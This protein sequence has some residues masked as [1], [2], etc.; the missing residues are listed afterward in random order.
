MNRIYHSGAVP[1]AWLLPCAWGL[2]LAAAHVASAAPIEDA[3]AS[4][5]RFSNVAPGVEMLEL[6]VAK[7]SFGKG[8]IDKCRRHLDAARA[9][10]S[11]Q[12]GR[13]ELP[14]TDLMLARL[15][16]AYGKKEIAKGM[17][18]KIAV[19]HAGHPEV[20]LLFGNLALAEG[21]YTDAMLHFEKSLNVGRPA[22]WIE[23]Q[24]KALFYES[25]AGQAKVAER[26]EDWFKAQVALKQCIKVEPDK[27]DLR[28]RLGAALFMLGREEEA[29][30]QF[31]TA[32]RQD[33][34][35]NPAEVSMGVMF[36]RTED[37][38]SSRK[39]FE[40]ALKRY[41]DDGRVHYEMAGVLLLSDQAAEAKEHSDK[42]AEMGIDTPQL[43]MQR[44]YIARQLRD[45]AAAE[46][47]FTQAL[48]QSPSDFEAMNQL[49]LVLIEQNDEKK[50]QRARELAELNVRRFPKSSHPLS[51]LGWVYY[52]LGRKD[53]A[54]RALQ[55]A[56]SRAPVRTESL[57]YL[58][59]LL[60]ENG[61]KDDR[62]SW[63]SK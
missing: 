46:K 51:T 12:E 52:K 60:W 40:A 8:D 32:A 6:Q 7:E 62:T 41:P 16:V 11:E 3:A 15:Y 10:L 30:E 43:T 31:Q 53:E 55:M 13:G 44:G 19:E 5:E 18:E 57:Y 4:F 26:R 50:Q 9:K 39:A 61:E 33:I 38:N 59:R 37:Y 23:S 34:K 21:R 25:Y 56:V 20:Y 28:D 49:A 48:T 14:P 54:R 63:P 27:A 1:V 47:F 35:M 22:G 58:T 2:L 42:A 36:A 24:A 17:L 29:F 45:Y